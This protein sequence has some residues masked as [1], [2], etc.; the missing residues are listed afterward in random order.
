VPFFG[1]TPK[2]LT[3]HGFSHGD[4]IV[5]AFSATISATAFVTNSWCSDAEEEFCISL[6]CGASVVHSKRYLDSIHCTTTELRT[7]VR[8]YGE[9]RETLPV[10]ISPCPAGSHGNSSSDSS[11]TPAIP[12]R[13]T[14]RNY[15]R[16]P[17][18]KCTMML[19]MTHTCKRKSLSNL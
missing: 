5:M 7:K 17:R 12:A 6:H 15:W 11:S 9:Q 13:N 3:T 14:P 16:T 18:A 19:V 2:G 10:A 8:Q 4:N 1:T